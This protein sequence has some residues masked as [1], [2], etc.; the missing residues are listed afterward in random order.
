MKSNKEYPCSPKLLFNGSFS[1]YELQQNHNKTV[2]IVFFLATFKEYACSA[3]KI[4]KQGAIQGSSICRT[5]RGKHQG[6]K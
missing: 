5:L 6:K 1:S 4:D 3:R 2:N